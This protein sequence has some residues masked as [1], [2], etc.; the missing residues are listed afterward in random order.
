MAST[1]K[2]TIGHFAFAC[3]MSLALVCALQ[4]FELRKMKDEMA[5][6]TRSADTRI[7][8]LENAVAKIER[9][10]NTVRIVPLVTSVPR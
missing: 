3:S 8:K 2:L 5:A 4:F 6:Q 1:A 7:A 9:R 10:L